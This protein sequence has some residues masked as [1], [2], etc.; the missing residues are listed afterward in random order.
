MLNALELL[1]HFQLLNINFSYV[2]I[3]NV[4][5]LITARI[6]GVTRAPQ[7][8]EYAIVTEFKNGANLS[9]IN[10]TL[11]HYW[12]PVPTNRPMVVELWDYLY[13][14]WKVLNSKYSIIKISEKS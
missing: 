11:L 12:D 9:R 7:S 14:F 5:I 6:Y 3:F 4:D 13:E 8:R 1:Q 10:E 2:P